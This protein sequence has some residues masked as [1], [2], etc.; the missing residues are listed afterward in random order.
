MKH[1]RMALCLAAALTIG[2]A[3]A[4]TEV[5]GPQGLLKGQVP[6][7]LAGLKR[8][9]ITTFIVQYVTDVGISSKRNE[10][11]IFFSK[12]K[13]PAPEV[14]QAAADALY[15]QLVADLKA[16]G[17]DV[18]DAGEVAAHEAIVEMRKS[19]QPNPAVFS[20]TPLK[21]AS[22]LFAAKGLP[23]V[24]AT[25]QDAKLG[26]YATKPLEG[27]DPPRNLVGWDRQAREWLGGGGSEVFSLASIFLG[28][29]KVA[30]SLNATALNVRMTVPLVDLGVTTC[31][32]TPGSCSGWSNVT[33]LIKPNPRIVEAGT[34]F[35][36]MQSTGNPG[37]L[38][39]VALQQPVPITG[40]KVTTDVEKFEVSA[41]IFGGGKRTARGGGLLGALAGGAGVNDEKADF[42]VSF[43]AAEL[44]P[45]LVS[46]GGPI[47]KELAQILS[48]PK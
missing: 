28:Q 10:S 42:W 20:S 43:D 23:L 18:V 41:S 32:N 29:A 12:W 48:N 13:E 24:V 8:V 11:D 35:S 27:T 46:A 14:M 3:N 34:V 15:E 7:N 16:A 39:V 5:T 37:H 47:F 40:L 2:V 22:K 26:S 6:D 36:F 38:H 33:G 17:V 25:V 9:A 21:K 30:T 31:G 19:G 1:S 44:Q 45:A 4:A